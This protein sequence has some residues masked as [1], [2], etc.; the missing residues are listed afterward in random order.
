MALTEV[1]NARQGIGFDFLRIRLKFISNSYWRSCVQGEI[2]YVHVRT[3]DVKWHLMWK[4]P[5]PTPTFWSLGRRNPSKTARVGEG[6]GW[7]Y[8]FPL[9]KKKF[10][11][12]RCSQVHK[13]ISSFFGEVENHFFFFSTFLE[14]LE[15]VACISF[16]GKISSYML[17][18]CGIQLFLIY[19]LTG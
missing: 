5:P 15:G 2:S 6:V 17:F 9:D 19:K 18:S 7:S 13:N 12:F 16:S 10:Y 8:I 3:A 1:I 11:F 4:K 14:H